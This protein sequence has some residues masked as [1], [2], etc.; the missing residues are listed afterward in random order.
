MPWRVSATAG[1]ANEPPRQ[2]APPGR[3]VNGLLRRRAFVR[4]R[5]TPHARV[6]I[7]PGQ[8]RPRVRP[9]TGNEDTHLVP[10]TGHLSPDPD[11]T[12]TVIAHTWMATLPSSINIHC[13]RM[14]A[15]QF[16]TSERGACGSTSAITQT[17]KR[18]P[19][20]VGA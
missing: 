8:A 10:A 15:I 17:R 16:E 11:N 3:R 2:E 9:D 14:D 19:D 18:W 20:R 4:K 1:R 7:S 6:S 13:H 5:W 12:S